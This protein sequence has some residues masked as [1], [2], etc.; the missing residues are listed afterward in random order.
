MREHFREELPKI[1]FEGMQHY[2]IHRYNYFVADLVTSDIEKV[3][4]WLEEEK[5]EIIQVGFER[6]SYGFN[7][8]RIITGERGENL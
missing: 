8:Y 3:L 7:N 5:A 2:I 4:D 1:R 6:N